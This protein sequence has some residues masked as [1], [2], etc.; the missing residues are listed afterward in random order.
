MIRTTVF[1][2]EAGRREDA[3]RRTSALNVGDPQYGPTGITDKNR[4]IIRTADKDIAEI[5]GS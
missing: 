3:K 2:I 5:Q 4:A 1:N